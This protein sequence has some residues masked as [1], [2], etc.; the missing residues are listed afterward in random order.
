MYIIYRHAAF[1]F[2]A[3]VVIAVKLEAKMDFYHRLHFACFLLVSCLVSSSTPEMNAIRSSE[4]PVDFCRATQGYNPENN[5]RCE[6]I[7]CFC[8]D[9]T[10]I[11]LDDHGVKLTAHLNI[12]SRSRMVELFLHSLIR[13]H[14][15]MLN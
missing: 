8:W 13:F 15:V 3:S 9:S 6:N 14:G 1:N 12:V 5:D 7:S 2:V 11:G 4:M 10:P